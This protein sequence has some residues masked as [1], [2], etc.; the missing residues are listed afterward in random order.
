MKTFFNTA[1]TDNQNSLVWLNFLISQSKQCQRYDLLTI[2]VRIVEHILG[3]LRAEVI[4]VFSLVVVMVM[5][6]ALQERYTLGQ[7][8]ELLGYL[9][10]KARRY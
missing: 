10:G 4:V 8:H 1:A 2:A 7:G 3:E 9:K 5:V 6:R